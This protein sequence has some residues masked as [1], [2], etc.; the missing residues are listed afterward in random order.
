MAVAATTN[1]ADRAALPR[2]GGLIICIGARTSRF[3]PEQTGPGPMYLLPQ[4]AECPGESPA[5]T[6]APTPLVATDGAAVVIEAVK[7]A[8]DGSGDAVVRLYESLGGRAATRLRPAFAVAEARTTHLLERPLPE[9]P[10]A[11]ADDGARSPSAPSR[12]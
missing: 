4:V 6:R 10:L 7:L 11:L 5:D 9:P 2:W 12:Y 3:Y 8:D 1:A